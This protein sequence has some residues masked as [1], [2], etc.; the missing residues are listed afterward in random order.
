MENFDII[1]KLG[2][3]TF[4][5]VFEGTELLSEKIYTLKALK[6]ELMSLSEVQ[7]LNEIRSLKAL[8]KHPNII[9]LYGV[10]F[11]RNQ[12]ILVL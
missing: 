9:Q 12:G 1:Q 11:E 6:K 7:N 3:G 4:S 2:E 8:G 10:I 5:Q